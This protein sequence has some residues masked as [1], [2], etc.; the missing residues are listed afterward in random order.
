MNV[1]HFF[2]SQS[3]KFNSRFFFILL[4]T[5]HLSSLY[6]LR[7]IFYSPPIVINKRDISPFLTIALII[8]VTWGSHAPAKTVNSRLSFSVTVHG[9]QWKPRIS[10]KTTDKLIFTDSFLANKLFDDKI[11][12]DILRAIIKF[13]LPN[14]RDV[15][16]EDANETSTLPGNAEWITS[17]RIKNKNV[18]FVIVKYCI[19]RQTIFCYL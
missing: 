8:P 1:K 16:F 9:Y 11:I 17:H 14:R 10:I 7:Y 5:L 3:I 19:L 2:P 4:F 13:L 18:S 15:C 12:Y 6:F